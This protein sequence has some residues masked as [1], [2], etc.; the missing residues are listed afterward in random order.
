MEAAAGA[1]A[2]CTGGEE[3]AVSEVGRMDRVHG[4]RFWKFCGQRSALTFPVERETE[5][6]NW[7]MNDGLEKGNFIFFALFYMG[8][9]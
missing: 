6:F 5:N 4:G 8:T 3:E 9:L 2:R 1:A 7:G